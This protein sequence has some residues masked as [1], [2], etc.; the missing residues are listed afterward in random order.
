MAAAIPLAIGAVAGAVQGEEERKNISRFN[1][2]AADANKFSD[3]TG[4]FTQLKPQTGGALG[5]ALKGAVSFGGLGGG[6]GG[7]GGA[8]PQAVSGLQTGGTTGRFDALRGQAGPSSG[9]FGGFGSI[10]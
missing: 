2:G 5:G 4:R 7:G 8:A 9:G 1:K 10:A 6:L 3:V